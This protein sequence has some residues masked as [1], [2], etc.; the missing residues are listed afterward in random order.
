MESVA[1]LEGHA[2]R[3]PAPRCQVISGIDKAWAQIDARNLTTEGGRQVTRRAADAAAEIEYARRWLDSSGGSQIGAPFLDAEDL[4][5]EP[6]DL[7]SA[8]ELSIQQED[9]NSGRLLHHRGALDIARR[10]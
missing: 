2:I 10:G 7:R 3:Q 6:I 9:R 5:E 8:F 4:P 1:D